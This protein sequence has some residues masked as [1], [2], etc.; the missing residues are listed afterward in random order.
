MWAELRAVSFDLDDT[1]W[2]VE[3]VLVQAEAVLVAWLAR[4]YPK[5]AALHTPDAA[6]A[7]RYAIAQAEPVRAHD[8]SWVRTESLRQM[9]G[10]AGYAEGAAEEAFAVFHAARHQVAPYPDVVPALA[11][12]ARRYRLYALSNGNADVHR[13]PL[14]S[15]FHGGVSARHA[16]AA[17]PDRRIFNHLLEL[18]DLEPDHVLHVGDDPVTDVGGAREAGWHTAWVNRSNRRGRHSCNEP[19]PRSRICRSWCTCC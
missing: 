2:D 15:Y 3:P 5:L 12:L 7:R 19:T 1:L 6:R 17:K 18:A 11:T 8:L 9:A 4:H 16:G 13:T 10:E 14:A